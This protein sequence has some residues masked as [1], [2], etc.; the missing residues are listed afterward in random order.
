MEI[1]TSRSALGNK[2][3]IIGVTLSRTNAGNLM[4]VSGDLKS[5]EF[6]CSAQQATIRSFVRKSSPIGPT[7]STIAKIQ[8]TNK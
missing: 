6:L 5:A 7:M 4:S 1:I 2:P 3:R 8:H